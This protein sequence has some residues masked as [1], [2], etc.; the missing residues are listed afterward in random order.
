MQ[1]VHFIGRAYRMLK[2]FVVTILKKMDGIVGWN[3]SSKICEEMCKVYN[4]CDI[5]SENV[6]LI[7]Q[8]MRISLLF[9]PVYLICNFTFSISDLKKQDGCSLVLHYILMY[10]IFTVLHTSTNINPLLFLHRSFF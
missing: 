3:G 5:C 1:N 9:H 6:K 4:R 10:F 8:K 7:P 2:N